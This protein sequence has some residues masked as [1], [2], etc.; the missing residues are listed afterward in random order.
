MK[1]VKVIHGFPPDYMAGSEVYSYHLV[2]ALRSQGEDVSVFTSV[3]NAFD[4]EYKVYDECYQNIPVRR[5]N[6]FRR[7]YQYQHKFYDS[8]MDGLFKAY[9]EELKPDLVH[10]GHLSHLST[11]L[12]PIAKQKYGLPIVFTIHDFWMFCVKGQLINQD[13]KICQS[14]SVDRCLACSPYHPTKSEV[15][16]TLQHMQSVIDWVDIF[17]SPSHTLRDFY[18][19]QGVPEEKVVY[20]KYGFDTRKINYRPKT[21]TQQSKIKFGFMGRIIPTKGIRVLIDAFKNIDATLNIYG[22]IGQEKRFLQFDNIHFKGGYD[23]HSIQSVLA[24]IDVLI[25]PS[26]WYENSPLVIQEA[27]LAGIPVITSNLG[28]MKELVNDGIN[29]Y[30]FEV[31]NAQSLQNVVL[32]ITA[33]PVMLNSLTVSKQEVIDIQEDAQFVRQIYHQVKNQ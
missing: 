3:E 14:P 5:V 32:Q 33:N 26:L 28:G 12:I 1:I 9:L 30:L 29:G 6:K 20:S 11:Q 2:K 10:F 22:Q 18:L 15:E 27:F 25:V 4:P 19:K 8:Q 16:K 7:D 21:Y 24:N 23:N 17:L 13:G 31:G